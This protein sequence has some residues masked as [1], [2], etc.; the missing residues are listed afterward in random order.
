MTNYEGRHIDLK[1]K[2]NNHLK[3]LTGQDSDF[4]SRLDQSGLIE[5]KNVL[6]D[7]HNVLTFKT[8]VCAAN[9]LCKFF[10]LDNSTKKKVLEIVDKTKPNTKGFDIIISEPYKIIAE[11]KC[12]SPVN[13]GEKFGAAQWNSI[14]DDF[15]K[16]KNGKGI[17]LDTSQYYKFLFLLDLGD[18]TDNAITQLLKA[19][20]GTSVKLLR[21]NRHRIKEHISL[22]ADKTKLLDIGFEKVYLKKIKIEK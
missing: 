3:K 9:W 19:S 17:L 1:N 7:I 4:Y 11:V 18:R 22:M 6:A 12:I 13:N 16:L 21:A 2:I 5:L 14:L 15:N 10:K 8:T 20:K